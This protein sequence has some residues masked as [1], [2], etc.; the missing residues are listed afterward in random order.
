ML[1]VQL[2]PTCTNAGADL[3][4]LVLVVFFLPSTGTNTPRIHCDDHPLQI[5]PGGVFPYIHPLALILHLHSC[6]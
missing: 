2:T 6:N 5:C 1:L 3:L 4:Q